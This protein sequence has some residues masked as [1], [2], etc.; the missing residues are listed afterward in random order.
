MA[1]PNSLRYK[2]PAIHEPFSM[3]KVAVGFLQLGQ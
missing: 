1:Q 2:T 3:K